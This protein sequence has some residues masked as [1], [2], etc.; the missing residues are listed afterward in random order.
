[1]SATVEVPLTAAHVHDLGAIGEAIRDDT[2]VVYLC[3]P[4]KP[5]GDHR[6]R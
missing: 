4:N 3:N 2:T 5:L 6:L 1:M